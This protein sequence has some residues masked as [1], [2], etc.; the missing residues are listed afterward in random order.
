MPTWISGA[1]LYPVSAVSGRAL[2]TFAPQGARLAHEVEPVV[3]KAI[4]GGPG[5]DD[6]RSYNGA[7]TNGAETTP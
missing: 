7:S 3:G 6:N 4:T 2:K 5:Q 1:L